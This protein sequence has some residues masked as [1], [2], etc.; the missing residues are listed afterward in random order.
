MEK[1]IKK[2]VIGTKYKRNSFETADLNENI[3]AGVEMLENIRMME[4]EDGRLRGLVK[5]RI[6]SIAC[7]EREII[8]EGP[9]ADFAREVFSNFDMHTII[10][11]MMTATKGGYSVVENIWGIKDSRFILSDLKPR[12]SAR[13][14]FDENDELKIV[15]EGE[16]KG[17]SVG[18][19]KFVTTT[20]DGE[21]KKGHGLYDTLFHPFQ[22][23]R[24]ITKCLAIFGTN[25][26]KPMPILSHEDNVNPEII[27]EA[28]RIIEF[29]DNMAGVRLPAGI[30]LE[31]L[32]AQKYGSVYTFEKIIDMVNTEYAILIQG[33]TLSSDNKGGG[34]YGLG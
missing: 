23:K 20:F 22:I 21:S 28:D 15:V 34:S 5:T 16:D 29:F 4:R 32:E 24:A 25:N 8:G 13:F 9:E 31:L 30:K 1:E 6:D 7:Q 27:E 3:G 18:R 11:R 33:Q 17:K 26:A 12:S 2:P 14:T 19:Y 10:K